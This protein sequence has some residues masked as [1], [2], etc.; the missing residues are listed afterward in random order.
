M[1]QTGHNEG[2]DLWS[3]APQSSMPDKGTNTINSHIA[4]DDQVQYRRYTTVGFARMLP[5]VTS[6]FLHYTRVLRTDI[7]PELCDENLDAVKLS[8]E[9][10]VDASIDASKQIDAL[11]QRSLSGRQ[12]MYL[13]LSLLPTMLP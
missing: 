3:A 11:C 2:T 13:G 6:N 4:I 12:A 10:V 7:G 1:P 9:A 5:N 8:D